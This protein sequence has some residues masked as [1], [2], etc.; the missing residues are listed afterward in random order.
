MASELP[1]VTVDEDGAA[2]LFDGFVRPRRI[3]RSVEY[4]ERSWLF[5]AAGDVV[6]IA[7][8]PRQALF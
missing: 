3:V 4:V 7:E 5:D 6:A 2:V 8:Q 1:I